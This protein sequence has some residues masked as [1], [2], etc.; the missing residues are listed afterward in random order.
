MKAFPTKIAGALLIELS[1]FLDNRGAFAEGFVRSKLSAQGID[2]EVQRVNLVRNEKAGTVRGMHWQADPWA[3]GKIV[4][5][6]SGKIFDAIVD[7]RKGSPTYGISYCVML[8]PQVNALFIPRGVAH[9]CQAMEDGASL[10]YL[11]D[12]EYMPAA[13]RGINPIGAIDWPLPQVNV[14]SR[15]LA[16]PT[17]KELSGHA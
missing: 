5:A 1:P 4:M 16:W 13:E 6:A 10:I 15:D 12:N 7:V 8:Y 9:G 17:L 3:Q 2:F 11:V 14:A